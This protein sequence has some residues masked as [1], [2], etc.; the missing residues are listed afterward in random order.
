MQWIPE[1][2]FIKTHIDWHDDQ[3]TFAKYTSYIVNTKVVLK[4]SQ[5][6]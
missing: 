1:P 3:L 4:V 2:M 6:F 5:V